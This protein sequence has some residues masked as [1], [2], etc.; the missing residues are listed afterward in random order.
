[1]QRMGIGVLTIGL[2]AA[3]AGVLADSGRASGQRTPSR[4]SGAA[5]GWIALSSELGEHRQVV[6]IDPGARVMTVYHVS[7][8]TGEI[9]LV[10]AR[11]LTWDQKF[12][13]FNTKN[14]LP[15]EIRSQIDQN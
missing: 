13:A 5:S 15:R 12:E 7:A 11:D 2:L 4:E 8:S 14:P 10:S 3:A 1:M 9:S 6:V